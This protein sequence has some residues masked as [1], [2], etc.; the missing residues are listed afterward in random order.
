MSLEEQEVLEK[1]ALTPNLYVPFQYREWA[2]IKKDKL[3]ALI[4]RGWIDKSEEGYK[5][6]PLIKESIIQQE[7][8]NISNFEELICSVIFENEDNQLY[9]NVLHAKHAL[10]NL[11]YVF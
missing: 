4:N 6:H 11:G 2:G 8:I 5:M 3:I 1:F 9:Q 7:V 10:E